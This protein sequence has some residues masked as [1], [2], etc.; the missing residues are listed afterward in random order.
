M[1]KEF[2]IMTEACPALN[3]FIYIQNIYGNQTKKNERRFP[4]M[5]RE[6]AFSQN[7]EDS[8]KEKW[9]ETVQLVA[10]NRFNG[11]K[12]FYNHKNFF[13]E[14]LFMDHTS[15]NEVYQSFKVWWQS[16]TGKLAVTRTVDEEISNIYRD[17]AESSPRKTLFV[18]VI[19]DDCFLGD[20]MCQPYFCIV[21]MEQCLHGKEK[22]LQ[23]VRKS[24]R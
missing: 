23:F 5:I 16:L 3:F 6:Y 19:Y 22:L 18:Q 9:A 17:L 21:T 7:F 24:M 10:E 14:G 1:N 20:L 11:E 15:F 12:L 2:Y 8:Y 13:F 4:Y